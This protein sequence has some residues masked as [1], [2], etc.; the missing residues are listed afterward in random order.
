MTHVTPGSPSLT[1]L[2]DRQRLRVAWQHVLRT[3]EAVHGVHVMS[4][5]DRDGE[6]R[7]Y[8]QTSGHAMY[9]RSDP[10]D[11]SWWHH[12]TWPQALADMATPE[13]GYVM[14]TDPFPC[15]WC[16]QLFPNE[17]TRDDHEN[18]CTLG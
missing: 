3:G 10:G 9:A 2:T 17:G 15:M 13:P 16:G 14:G 1:N 12:C 8:I 6:P 5:W 7:V 18:G 4:S 11:W